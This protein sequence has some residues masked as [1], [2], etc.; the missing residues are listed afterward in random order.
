MPEL[1]EVQT[2]VNDLQSLVGQELSDFY[3]DFE[4]AIKGDSM[5]SLREKILGTRIIGIERVAKNIAIMLSSG[6]AIII[7][8]KMTGKLILEKNRTHDACNY[9]EKR[10]DKHFH[11]VFIFNKSVLEFHDIRKFATLELLNKNQWEEKLARQ[12]M[13]PAKKNFSFVTFHEIMQS[14]KNK[15]IKPVLMDGS[16]IA[17]IGNIYASEILFDANILPQRTLTS[18]TRK[19][20]QTIHESIKNIIKKAIAL[21]GTSISDYRDGQGKKGLFQN[22]LKVYKKHGKD[23]PTCGTIIVRTILAQRSSFYCPQCQK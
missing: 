20:L 3:S 22:H 14:Q 17:G 10:Q 7:H 19:E 2:I 1:P 23:C 11:H 6:S 18:L 21:R 8:L 15:K 4:K 5:D 9:L 12:A 16:V 13:D